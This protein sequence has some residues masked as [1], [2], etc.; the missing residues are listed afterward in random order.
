M[1][2]LTA[3][4]PIDRRLALAAG[5]PLPDRV[6]GVA[7][8]ADIS[9][10]TP[11]TA[12]LAQE[13][14]PHRGAEELTRQLNL[15]FADLIAQVHH[16]QGNVIGFSGDAITCWF[17]EAEV[18]AAAGPATN[19]ADL[20]LACALEL[21]QVMARIESV[22]TPRGTII[23]LALK[24][25]LAAGPARRFLVGDPE[26]YV[27]EV[28]AGATL[29]Q[30]AAGEKHASQGEVVVTA[31]FVSRLSSPPVIGE[32][33]HA[34]AGQRFAVIRALA[35]PVS[36]AAR[37]VTSTIGDEVARQWL[38]PPVAARLQQSSGD[39]LAELRTAVV[40]FLGFSGIDY[41]ND[42]AA[43]EKL[44]AFV[45]RT[46][47]IL[48][49][50]EGFLVQL[51]M[52]DKGSYL[53]I[54]FGAP[55]AHENDAVRAAAAAMELRSL[56]AQ[57]PFLQPVRI[58]ISQ[59]LTHSGAYGGFVRRTY[60]VMGNEVNISARL[61]TTAVPGQILISARVAEDVK[62]GYEL[63]ALPPVH[64]KGLK[65][66]MPVW[67][68]HQRQTTLPLAQRQTAVPMIGRAAE[69]QQLADALDRLKDGRSGA[70]LIEGQAGIGK[71][72]LVQE[73]LAM[74]EPQTALALF[75]SGDAIEQSTPYHAWRPIFEQLFYP[76]REEPQA[77]DFWLA[78]TKRRLDP[79]LHDLLPL[80]QV[81]F[82]I[83]LP[84]T[85]LTAN[86][87]GEARRDNT[88]RLLIQ[89]LETAVDQP[90]IL[91]LE[92]A[93]WLDSASWTL[94][95]RVQRQL[96]PLL[97]VLALRPFAKNETFPAFYADLAELPATLRIELDVL[98]FAAVEELVCH[99][100]GVRQL[101][102]AVSK[103]IH[104]KA[105][106]HPFF[107]EE[108]AYALRD[109]GLILI[110]NGECRLAANVSDFEALNFPNT[111]QGVI[112]SRIDRLSP[113]Q[114]LTVKV[115]S[116]I[117]RI[118]AFSLLRGIYPVS[119]G[120]AELRQH[121]E[122]LE[123]LDITPIET[124]DPNLAYIFKHLVTQEV[125]Y[126]LM[127][128]A[129]RQ[130]LHRR[131]AVWYEENQASDLNRSY[132]LLAHHWHLAGD[133]ERAVMYY[134]KAGENAF[135]DYANQE[136]IRFFTQA[137]ELSS[138]AYPAAQRARWQRQMGEAA[139]RLTQVEQSQDH[140]LAALA[141]LQRP[142][143]SSTVRRALGLGRQLTRQARYYRRAGQDLERPSTEEGQNALLE[144]AR[145]YEGVSEIYY[146][147]GDFLTTF[148]CVMT[149][150]NLSEQSG[151]SPE[152][153]R[154]YA[155][156]CPTLGTVALHNLAQ[157][158]RER[159]LVMAAQLDDLTTTAYIQIPFSSYSLWVGDW[160]RAEKEVDQALAIYSRLGDWRRWCV[161][162]WMW[163]QVAQSQAQF[164]R[165][166]TLWSELYDVALSS[167]DTRHQ[168]RSRG[169]QVFNLLSLGLIDEAFVCGDAVT[170]LLE[171]NP[172]MVSVEERLWF[173]IRALRA[174][175]EERW[176]DAAHLAHEQI[177]AIG[178]A[179][180]KFDLLEVFAASAEVFLA[181]WEQG[182]GSPK[183]ARQGCQVLNQYARTYP[184]ARPRALRNQGCYAWLA[185]KRSR[186]QKL[187][188]KSLDQAAA[189]G[190][191]YEQT[192]TRQVMQNLPQR[193]D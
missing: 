174:L 6:Q 12:V 157:K 30:M 160:D 88:Q 71:S 25:A 130:Q 76:E 184:F 87:T 185:G 139:Y 120:A 78:E 115:A 187:W 34:H 67:E 49:Y 24:V 141:L 169:G 133:T 75:G 167:Q 3:F 23:P 128:F 135:R 57:F 55:I 93:H 156:M 132:P 110:E 191:P 13:L 77:A 66:P 176:A 43:G 134:E 94:L 119:T 47:A 32:W 39:F 72:R 106:G 123:R 62:S 5:R 82:P 143:P 122:D 40:M 189:L 54:A 74:V 100:L 9:G 17:D 164:E 148:Y 183:E 159:T 50:Y 64:L 112:T 84:E 97:L 150:L 153:V 31:E 35:Q 140:Y 177:A 79:S 26:L 108:L 65:Q 151:L 190:M 36:S 116:V 171:E 68:L 20:A 170:G 175:H 48:N 38:L 19:V 63:E 95:R 180:F 107:S 152:L 11:L 15:V 138:E 27:I 113:P 83:D 173:A 14:G 127:T 136:A 102:T 18:A 109:A 142:L 99:S 28:L 61:M 131:T 46:Q 118:F 56:P 58:G 8:F 91:V 96:Q 22:R 145:A 10:F 114:Q 111:I 103:L 7:L 60:A 182:L 162:A 144:A 104:T 73:L 137:L 33:R 172:E 181:L 166:R 168:V 165:A 85:E 121:L 192:L 1:E 70:L 154:N 163:P 92:D 105:E 37:L 52:G 126:N 4:L 179:R 45:C 124:P 80:L 125:V 69:R 89:L 193:S 149:A 16:Y 29:D 42:D 53:Y 90:L 81:I 98:P 86:L 147:T 59:G 101:P 158:Y 178:R 155:N 21:Q 41:D 146:N 51:T 161:A 186:A 2:S 129:Q 117:G 44:D 188:Q